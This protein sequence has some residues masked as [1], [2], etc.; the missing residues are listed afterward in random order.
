MFA[1]TL[2]EAVAVAVHLQ[3]VDMVGKPIE[4][5]ASKAFGSEDFGPFLEGQIAGHQ[6]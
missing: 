6:R 2:L 3:D 1:A 4:Q 5:G